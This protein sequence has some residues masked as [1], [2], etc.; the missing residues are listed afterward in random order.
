MRA[1]L[2]YYLDENPAQT[3]GHDGGG[4]DHL[5]DQRHLVLV[6]VSPGF[7]QTPHA[8]WTASVFFSNLL[9]SAIFGI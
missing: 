4:Q 5:E 6:P 7:C 3:A 8:I 1:V 2:L 9:H